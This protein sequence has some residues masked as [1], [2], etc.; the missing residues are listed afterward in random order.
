MRRGRMPTIAEL[1]RAGE[2]ERLR[3]IRHIVDDVARQIENGLLSEEVARELVAT[4]R[5][6]AGLLIPDQMETFDLIYSSRFDR[7]IRQFIR[8]ES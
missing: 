1:K 7:L 3:V 5:F 8:G 6:Q 2:G 4:V